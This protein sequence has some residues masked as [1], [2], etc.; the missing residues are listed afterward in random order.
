MCGGRILLELSVADDPAW[1]YFDGQHKYIMNQ[2]NA[3][4]KAALTSIRS[5]YPHM[6]LFSINVVLL[7]D[8]RER[9][10]PPI[11]SSDALNTVLTQQLQTCIAALETKQLESLIGMYFAVFFA[12]CV[13]H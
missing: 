4:Y 10:S 5:E 1:T 7:A 9:N 12:A 13:G 6:I 8:I 11:P 3:S 2:M